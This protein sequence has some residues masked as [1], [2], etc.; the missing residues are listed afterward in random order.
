MDDK[1]QMKIQ[2]TEGTFNGEIVEYCG[3]TH[4]KYSDC[5]QTELVTLSNG[6]ELHKN[7]AKA[8]NIMQKAAQK[9][10]INIEVVSGYR[11]TESQKTIFP[12]KFKGSNNPPEE[13]FISRLKES[14]P[15]GYSEHHTG[16]AADIND[17]EDD[18]QYTKEYE[19]LKK[20]ACEYNF[21][22]S[23]PENNALG[24]IFEPWHWRYTGD[25]MTKELFKN[26][27]KAL[28]LQ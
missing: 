5:P 1:Q 22:Q 6:E 14:A 26:A 17:T 3:I 24:L 27:R 12:R 25:D 20:H 11:S 18:F 7:C 16:F 23:F 2:L 15:A 9:D 10:G 28:G 19:W 21:E 8:F 13:A 4:F